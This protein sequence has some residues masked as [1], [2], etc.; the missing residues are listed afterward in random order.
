MQRHTF[1]LD[2]LLFQT[3]YIM[4]QLVKGITA[5]YHVLANKSAF[6]ETLA[7][8][9]H[10]FLSIYAMHHEIAWDEGESPRE[11]G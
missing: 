11:S 9:L 7:K 3:I 1:T 10:N 8:F 4:T 2:L 5:W 6:Y